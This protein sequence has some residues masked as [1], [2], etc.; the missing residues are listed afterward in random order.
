MNL[1]EDEQPVT[2]SPLV[3]AALVSF[4]LCAAAV[5]FFYWL[6]DQRMLPWANE[7]RW[8]E[9]RRNPLAPTRD[10][11]S[12][13]RIELRRV[14]CFGHCP[15]Y[16][17]VLFASGRVEYHGKGFVC[18]IGRRDAQIDA[19]AASKLIADFVDSGYFELEWKPGDQVSDSPTVHTRLTVGARS[20]GIEHYHGDLDAPRV[21]LDMER[22]IDEIAGTARW[23]PKLDG[24]NRY[25]LTADDKRTP[26]FTNS[27]LQPFGLDGDE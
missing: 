18:E 10:L 3:Y 7:A 12:T 26:P 6:A 21:L 19:R 15:V 25:C 13:D 16:D 20:R 24:R 14:M 23:L 1:E 22:A 5:P 8:Q 9:L 27:G 11:A 2:L 17:L 4:L